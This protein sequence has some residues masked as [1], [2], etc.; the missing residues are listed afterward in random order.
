MSLPDTR[1]PGA[2]RF[3]KALEEESEGSTVYVDAYCASLI[4]TLAE[5]FPEVDDYLQV[6]AELMEGNY[7]KNQP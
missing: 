3:R 5:L 4:I 7:A 6:R 2:Q 1:T